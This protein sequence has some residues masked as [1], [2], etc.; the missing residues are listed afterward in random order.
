M[1]EVKLN[2]SYGTA[3]AEFSYGKGKAEFSYGRGKTEFVL[4][5]K[6]L[7]LFLCTAAVII[8]R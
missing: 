4:R 5:T 6:S 7:V 8:L 1:A 2:L 3:K